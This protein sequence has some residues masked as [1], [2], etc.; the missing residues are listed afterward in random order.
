M[1][2]SKRKK[3]KKH[4]P[5]GGDGMFFYH[6]KT[7]HPAKQISHTEKTWTNKRFTHSPNRMKDYVYDS[8]TS[9]VGN[10]SYMTKASFTDVIYTRGQP[11]NMNKYKKSVDEQRIADCRTIKFED[12]TL[13]SGELA[14][15]KLLKQKHRNKSIK[16]KKLRRRSG[17]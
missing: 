6:K 13:L 2:K 15:A 8:S 3:H 7:K 10:P 16:N 5:D 9:T 17:N 1:S 4:Y 11:Y 14:S 12:S